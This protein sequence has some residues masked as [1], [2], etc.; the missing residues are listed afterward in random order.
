MVCVS[1][2]HH[3]VCRKVPDV[4]CSAY[5]QINANHNDLLAFFI[6]VLEIR[7]KIVFRSYNTYWLSNFNAL[8][9]LLR[10]KSLHCLFDF[11]LLNMLIYWLKGCSASIRR[12]YFCG[13][14]VTIMFILVTLKFLRWY[15]VF[16]YLAYPT[17]IILLCTLN[18]TGGME[19]IQLWRALLTSLMNEHTHQHLHKITQ[20]ETPKLEWLADDKG[21]SVK[22]TKQNLNYSCSYCNHHCLFLVPPIFLPICMCWF[23][24]ISQRRRP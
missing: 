6:V 10:I 11:H 8:C 14:A 23:N 22:Q 9:W 3:L 5:S 1:L 12:Y 24:Y 2:D 13:F 4:Y 7:K 21:E 20:E 19:Q 16:P 18:Q 17:L 15:S